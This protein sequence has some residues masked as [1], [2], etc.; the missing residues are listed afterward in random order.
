[1]SNFHLICT[2]HG[3]FRRAELPERQRRVL[4]LIEL[5]HDNS[6][7]IMD[8]MFA[9]WPLRNIVQW[10]DEILIAA[11]ELVHELDQCKDAG[12]WNTTP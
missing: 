8:G 5:I 7:D 10:S 3:D 11:F 4:E 9:P 6:N 1:M 2:T 12:G